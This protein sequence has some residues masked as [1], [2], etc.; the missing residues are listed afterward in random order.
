MRAVSDPIRDGAHGFLKVQFTAVCKIGI[1]V[2]MGIYGSYHLRPKMEVPHGIDKLGTNT[3]GLLGATTFAIGAAASATTGYVTMLVS[4]QTNIR[5]ASAA[6]RSYGETL[7]ICFRGGAFSAILALAM[8][9]GSITILYSIIYM[10]YV[11][12]GR[13]SVNE[14]PLLIVGYGFGASFVALF[15]QLGGGIYTKAADVGA[16]LVG[17]VCTRVHEYTLHGVHIIS[18]ICIIIIMF[19]QTADRTRVVPLLLPPAMLLMVRPW[20]SCSPMIQCSRAPM[21]PSFVITSQYPYHTHLTPRITHQTTV[22]TS[23][24]LP[25]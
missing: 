21:W 22:Y 25:C 10:L 20:P 14:I 18:I 23:P 3:L 9:I 7:L 1:F 5:V 6:R 13:L 8:C 16:D 12:S 17:K 15:M 24:I 19:H 11:P 2:T 4:A